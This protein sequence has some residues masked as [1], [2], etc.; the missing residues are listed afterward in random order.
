MRRALLLVG[1]VFFWYLVAKVLTAILR[2]R[3]DPGIQR[4]ARKGHRIGHYYR[5][6]GHDESR[7]VLVHQREQKQAA[8]RR[9]RSAQV[10]AAVKLDQQERTLADFESARAKRKAQG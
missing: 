2:R 7:A 10:I 1:P 3:P 8:Q 9:A 4:A 5:H 6:T